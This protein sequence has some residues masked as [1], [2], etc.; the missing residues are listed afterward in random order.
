MK[1]YLGTGRCPFEIDI[2]SVWIPLEA[3]PRISI[4]VQRIY[5]GSEDE[6]AGK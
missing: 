3:D 5:M 1:T 6:G 2:V 4:R